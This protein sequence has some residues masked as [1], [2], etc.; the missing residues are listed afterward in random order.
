MKSVLICFLL[1]ITAGCHRLSP[2][3]AEVA[4][5]WGEQQ[6]F[7]YQGIK[8]NYYEAGRQGPPVLLLHGFGASA[9]TWRF[10]IPALAGD[11]RVFTLDLKGHGFSDKPQD[12]KYA[13]S[14]Q[15][16]M[17]AAFLRARNLRD[18]VL[19]GNSMG[20]GV[21]LMT[22][23][24][25]RAEKPGRIKGL[26]LI[27]SAGYP[28]KLPCFIRLAR[29]PLLSDLGAKLLSPRF[30]AVLVLRKCYYNRDKITEEAI[31][32]YA[33]YGSLPGTAYAVRQTAKQIIPAD[34]EALI[35]QYRTIPVPCL[36]IWG[37][38][39]K[40]VPLE[41]ARNF[42]R[43]LQNSE[44]VILPQCGHIPQEEEPQETSRLI[45]DFLKKL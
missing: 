25:V 13:V 32:T 30:L 35:P 29:V 5:S 7:D 36:I 28:Q 44:L 34:M 33:Y 31:N 16:E 38:E 22:Y 10:L 45:R 43:D 42:K 1:L 18:A 37:R 4:Q 24:Q 3:T 27:D 12:G 26:V 17:V 39:D 40:V 8:I 21:A 41:N 6:T 14:D 2:P 23:L 9:Y 19:I 11:Y 15:A 20:G